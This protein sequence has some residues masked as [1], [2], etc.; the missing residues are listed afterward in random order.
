MQNDNNITQGYEHCPI[1]G[2]VV[3]GDDLIN[4]IRHGGCRLYKARERILIKNGTI[5]APCPICGESIH[6]A[7]LRNHLEQSHTENPTEKPKF[8]RYTAG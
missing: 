8:Y 2:I 4:H 6:R 5:E 1:C 7:E 3:H